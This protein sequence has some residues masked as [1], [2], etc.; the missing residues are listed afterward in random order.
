M[1]H[2]K[3]LR[4]ISRTV[5]AALLLLS[6]RGYAVTGSELKAEAVAYERSL[7]PDF[8]YTSEGNVA[9]GS[10]AFIGYVSGV[11]DTLD[12]TAFC[13]PADVKSGRLDSMVSKYVREHPEELDKRGNEL[14]V[15]ALRPAFPCEKK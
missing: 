8:D 3:N 4:S 13:I 11:R 10:P 7:E 9:F 12:G 6:G 1:T 5:L 14:V 15:S 2:R